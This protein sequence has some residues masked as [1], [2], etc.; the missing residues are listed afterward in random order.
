MS[1]CDWEITKNGEPITDNSKIKIGVSIWSSTDVLGVKCKDVLDQCARAL[2]VNIQYID[3][4][5]KS[6]EVVASVEK[7]CAAGCQGIIL[8]NSSDSEMISALKTCN[9]NKVYLAQ[10]FR[11]INQETNPEIYNMA[12]ESPMFVGSVFKM[13]T[14]TAKS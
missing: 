7:L 1:A 12:F 14:L 4:G 3:Q 8:C 2:G 9:D 6:E 13:K 10:F 5:H 11:H